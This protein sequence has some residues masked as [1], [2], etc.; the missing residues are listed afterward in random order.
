MQNNTTKW[1]FSKVKPSQIWKEAK[2]ACDLAIA[3]YIKENPD[4]KNG[5]AYAAYDFA[6]E[7]YDLEHPFVKYMNKKNIGKLH[8]NYGED[9]FEFT[10]GDI[11]K[12]EFQNF[13]MQENAIIAFASV[14]T[15]YGI[16]NV[17]S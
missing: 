17:F 4:Y 1:T 2:Q 8:S 11:I 13:H 12:C 5:G 14:L 9:V 6:I 16:T 3:E 10:F 7:I 15:S